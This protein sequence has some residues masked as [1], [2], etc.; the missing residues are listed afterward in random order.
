MT[1][2]SVNLI[3]P[4]EISSAGV[5]AAK[6][7]LLQQIEGNWMR[8]FGIYAW[9]QRE[10]ITMKS[11]IYVLT[12]VFLVHTA[13]GAETK[14]EKKQRLDETTMTLVPMQDGFAYFSG[15][16][17]ETVDSRNFITIYTYKNLN[18]EEPS[19]LIIGR[20]IELKYELSEIDKAME[21]YKALVVAK[22]VE[23]AVGQERGDA[24]LEKLEEL[25]REK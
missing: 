5:E 24:A 9:L 19:L 4:V 11:S 13:Q 16:L 2:G 22:W 1:L 6:P 15:N 3:S 10:G 18:D 7:I 23:F 20:G 25:L 12:F 21:A 14:T 8:Q 17:S